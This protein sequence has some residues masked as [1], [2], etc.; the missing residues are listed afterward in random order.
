VVKGNTN[1]PVD[2]DA[3][4][5]ELYEA[6]DS[7]SQTDSQEPQ[8]QSRNRSRIET[9]SL[10]SSTSSSS[11]DDNDNDPNPDNNEPYN[12]PEDEFLTLLRIT[13]V[14]GQ[15]KKHF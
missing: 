8:N 9:S 4:F 15:L 5:H 7:G 1:D 11:E 6:Q 2:Y 3:I 10:F 13:T 14:R 12:I